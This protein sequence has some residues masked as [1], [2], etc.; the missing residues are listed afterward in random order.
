MTV[1]ITSRKTAKV[2]IWIFQFTPLFYRF[3]PPKRRGLL[4]ILGVNQRQDGLI[5]TEVLFGDAED[6]LPGDFAYGLGVMLEVEGESKMPLCVKEPATAL[7][8]CRSRR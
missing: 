3:V 8:F 5:Q 7:F 6:V 1:P 2:M 4:M